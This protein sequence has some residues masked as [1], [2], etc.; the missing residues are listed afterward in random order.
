MIG[1]IAIL[2]LFWV[3]D[4][5]P[6]FFLM[7]LHSLFYVPTISIT[8]S[9]AFAHLKDAQKDF[10]L[11]RLWG[12]IGWIAASWPFVFILTDW[13]KGLWLIRSQACG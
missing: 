12:T 8:N 9:I 7:L 5:W 13:N 3:T 2:A 4:F 1:G 10:G 6:F 11:V